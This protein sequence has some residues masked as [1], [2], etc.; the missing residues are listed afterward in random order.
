[1]AD[2]KISQK[3][4]LS[5]RASDWTKQMEETQFGKIQ[6][7]VLESKIYLHDLHNNKIRNDRTYPNF[8]FANAGSVE[9]LFDDRTVT[10][11]TCI[12][13]YASFK[14][15]GGQFLKGS[16]AQEENLCH[17]SFLYNVL[18]RFYRTYYAQN[19]QNTYECLY[20]N[21]AIYT[22][23]ITFWCNHELVENI[24]LENTLHKDCDVLTCA[25][26]NRVSAQKYY[27][28]TDSECYDA[29]LSRMRFMKDILEEKEVDT[30]ITGAWGCGVFGGDIDELIDVTKRTFKKTT[31]KNIICAVPGDDE[32]AQKIKEFCLMKNS[33]R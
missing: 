4:K 28:K 18:K 1:M 26:P 17:Q 23:D 9:A 5:K 7:A 12:L 20:T 30:F 31:V 13:N 15:P 19:R 6:T 2:T 32:N 16:P 22:P 21:R 11:K 10:G 27:G 14:N 8:I 3:E 29:L 24:D 25:A 33:K